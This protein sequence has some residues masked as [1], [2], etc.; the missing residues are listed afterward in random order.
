MDEYYDRV[1]RSPLLGVL[2]PVENFSRASPLMWT[3]LAAVVLFILGVNIEFL[4]LFAWV[5]G[6]MVLLFVAV[7]LAFFE[8]M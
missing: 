8:A 1:G 7:G 6:F 3:F 4:Q 2:N 5:G